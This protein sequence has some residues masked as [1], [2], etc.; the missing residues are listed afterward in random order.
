MRRLVVP[1]VVAVLA[2]GLVPLGAAPVDIYPEFEPSAVQVQ[3]E[4]LGLSAEE[5][6]QLVTTP[7]EQDLLNGIPWLDS[8]RSQSMPGLSAIDLTF[9]PGTDLYRA[10]QMVQ[11]RM[12]QAAP[13]PNVGTPPVMVQP[14]ASTSR[15]AMVGLRSDDVSLIEMSVLA[16]WQMRPRLMAVPGVAQVSIWGQRERQLQVRVD[17][18]RLED[19]DVT[20]TQLIESTGNALWVSPLS[21]VEAST[22]GTGGFVE[23]P[24]QRIGVQHISP[25]TTSE[26]LGNVAIEGVEGPPVRLQDVADVVEDH[27]PLIGDAAHAGEPGLLLV[28]ERFPDAD[29]AQVTADV[30]DALDAMSA[31]LTGITVDTDLFRPAGYLESATDRLGIVAL[32]GLALLLAVVGLLTWSWRTVVIAFASTGTSLVAALY[33]LRLGG[34]PLTTMTLLGLAAV[35]AL[36]VDDVVGDVSAVR[37]R[38]AERGA[39][40]RRGFIPLVSAALVG[41]RSPL[42]YATL[43]ALLSVAPLL[44]LPGTVGAFARPAVLVFVL[45]ALASFLVAMV[46][47]PVLAVVLF[48]NGDAGERVSPFTATVQR[49]YDGF[50]GRSAGR[51][52]PAILGLVLLAGLMVAGIPQLGSGS[53]LPALDDPNVLVRLQAAPGTSLVEMDRVT[54]AAAADLRGLAGVES[55][56]MHTGRAVGADEI[57]DVDASEI[58]LR[59]NEDADHAGTLAAIRSTVRAYPGLHSEVS[60]Y[61]EDRVA[62]VSATSGDDL[63]VR[64]FGEDY[65]TLRA[66]ADQVSALL[67]TVE[68]VV[69]PRVQVQASQPTVSVQVDLASARLHDLRPGDVRREVSTLVSGLTVGSL[70][71]QQAIFDVVV[72]GGP[73]TRASVESLESLLVHTPTGEPVRLGDVARVAVTP[74]PTVISHDGASRSLDVT[75]QVRG[76]DVADVAAETTIRLQEQSF[77]LEYRAEVLG[78]AVQRADARQ[79][80]LLA[81]AAAAVLSFLL[82]QAATSSW[83]IAMAL[84]LAAPL[85]AAGAVLVGALADGQAQA[86]LLAAL[87]AVVALTVRQSLGVV[88]RA[89]DLLGGGGTS[90]DALRGAARE[91]SPAVLVTA[92]GTAAAFLPAAVVGGPGLELLQ[93]FAVALLGGLVTSVVVVIVLVPGLVAAGGGLRPPPVTRSG[94]PGGEGRGAG[95]VPPRQGGDEDDNERE[96]GAVMRT[97]RPCGIAALFVAGSLGLA[98]CQS[99]AGAD[100]EPAAPA[101]VE[102]DPAGGPAR[103]T[104]TEDAVTRIGLETV[105]VAGQAG[106][107]EIPYAAV[108]Y[109]AEG[110]TWTFVELEPGVYRRA[111]ITI[112]SVDDDTAVLTEGP[113]AGTAVV[114]VGAAELVGVEAG[115]SGQ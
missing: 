102:A 78:D 13:L 72:W 6:E 77:P 85:A 75:A 49:G 4:A 19:S 43:I 9:E 111:P 61:A 100:E 5:V 52:V 8:I 31:G 112:A 95:V 11:E 62:A 23:T 106:A 76:R 92:L 1:G 17:P 80:V 40:D 45:A 96:T 115:I 24:N 56:G 69:S 30:E 47:T 29:V 65:A 58:W 107:L 25:I 15:V 88:R 74:T 66:T 82:L 35:T 98:G 32:V 7:L 57:V 71:E 50:A 55:V 104:L 83:R 36:V 27:Q 70:Y 68:G 48:R 79:Q 10:R 34:A 33:V 99:V 54:E 73:Q 89:Q 108:V 64:V 20:L 97:A 105:P 81:V 114:T 2:L 12:S 84:F 46:V 38:A 110:G 26:Q 3:T 60:T 113:H 93:P 86:G 87:L 109:E 37:A 22:P 14:T 51:S 28:V 94:T 90:A 16:R 21:F 42:A 39:S 67:R 63:V 91:Q 18:E 59:I 103:L 41:R 53:P 44:L 101:S